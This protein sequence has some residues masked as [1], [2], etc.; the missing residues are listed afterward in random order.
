MKQFQMVVNAI[1]KLK[2]S[3]DMIDGDWE[4]G[5]RHLTQDHLG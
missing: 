3:S 1:E 2:Q 5:K 4:L